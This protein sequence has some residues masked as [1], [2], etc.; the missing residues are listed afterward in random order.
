MDPKDISNGEHICSVCEKKNERDDEKKENKETK[1]EISALE[2][3][4][5][6]ASVIKSREHES[7]NKLPVMSSESD[8]IVDDSSNVTGKQFIMG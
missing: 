4:A 1:E 5:V 3:L 7:S 6:A 8:R 2:L